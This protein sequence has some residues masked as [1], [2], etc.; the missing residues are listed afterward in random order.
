MAVHDIL[1]QDE[2]D[3]LLN[4]MGGGDIETESNAESNEEARNY[5]FGNEERI[6]RGRMPT[7][8]MVNERFGRL[9]RISLFNMLRRSAEISVSGVQIMKFSEYI[10][11]LFCTY[12]PQSYSPTSSSW[13]WSSCLRT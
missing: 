1:S 9:L 6:I 2:V 5:D 11:T 10:H 4:G 13:Y 8:E 3:A 7:L 12:K